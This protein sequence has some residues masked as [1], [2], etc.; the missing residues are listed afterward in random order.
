M[1]KRAH[2]TLFIAGPAALGGL[3]LAGCSSPGAPSLAAATQTQSPAAATPAQ[4]PAAVQAPL[5]CVASV[6]S[7]H[8]GDYTTVGVRVQTTPGARVTAVAHYRRSTVTHRQRASRHGRSTLWYQV[9]AARRGLRV[10]VDVT[11]SQHGRTGYCGTWFSPPRLPHIAAAAPPTPAPRPP[12][13]SPAPSAASC[14][15]LSSSGNCYRAGEFC[16]NADHGMSGIA[17]NGERIICTDNDGWRWE[18]A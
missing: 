1:R 17:D 12:A 18:P 16:S 4:S 7:K 6:T 14:Y 8:P 9:G 11:I 10:T 2:V 3:M 5:K 13:P 15:P